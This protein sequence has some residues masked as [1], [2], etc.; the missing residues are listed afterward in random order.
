MA[1]RTLAVLTALAL[2]LPAQ[3]R[4]LRFTCLVTGQRDLFACCCTGSTTEACAGEAGPAEASC[5]S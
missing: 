1:A 4:G 3:A 5:G 2:A